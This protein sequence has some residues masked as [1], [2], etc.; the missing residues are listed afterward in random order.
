[1]EEGQFTFAV[2]VIAAVGGATVLLAIAGV[3]IDRLSGRH[4]PEE[5]R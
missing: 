2:L 1:M 5:D 4:E 3:L